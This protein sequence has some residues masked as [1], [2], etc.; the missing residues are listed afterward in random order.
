MKMNDL[1]PPPGSEER[2][3]V[4]PLRNP[5]TYTVG[6]GTP[7]KVPAFN[8][9]RPGAQFIA[10]LL[11]LFVVLLLLLLITGTAALI[12]WIIREAL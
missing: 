12:L 7:P 8:Q 4:P 11:Y 10:G 9:L 3:R 5:P 2:S 6:G 1:P